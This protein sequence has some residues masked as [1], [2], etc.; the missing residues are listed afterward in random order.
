MSFTQGFG[1]N[2]RANACMHRLSL[3]SHRNDGREPPTL[4]PISTPP[5]RVPAVIDRVGETWPFLLVPRVVG[6]SSHVSESTTSTPAFARTRSCSHM[7]I[8]G[9][10]G[11]T[12]MA[13]CSKTPNPI[14]SNARM[15][16]DALLRIVHACIGRP[17]RRLLLPVQGSLGD[18]QGNKRGGRDGFPLGRDQSGLMGSADLAA[19]LV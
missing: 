9:E 14:C 3:A 18:D 16:M 11:S 13:P 7:R 8:D 2:S 4:P 1:A 19:R 17:C 5:S 12:F 15:R 10:G 6:S